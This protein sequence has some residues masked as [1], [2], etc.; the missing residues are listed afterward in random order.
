MAKETVLTT[1]ER[2]FA[3]WA[4]AIAMLL[5]AVGMTG[6]GV[7]AQPSIPD[8]GDIVASA[9]EAQPLIEIG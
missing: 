4:I 8:R 9:P 2:K 5:C 7:L 1:G 3:A 6:R